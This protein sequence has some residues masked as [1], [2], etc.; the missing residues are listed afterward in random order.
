VNRAL[1]HPT[2]RSALRQCGIVLVNGRNEGL[3]L[4]GGLRDHG[5]D[6]ASPGLTH[7]ETTKYRST[8]ACISTTISTTAKSP[9]E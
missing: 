3:R 7:T 4:L 8:T 1:A 5:A 2:C 6:L 9:D